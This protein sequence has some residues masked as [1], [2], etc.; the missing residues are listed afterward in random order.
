MIVITKTDHIL[1]GSFPVAVATD[2]DTAE[3]EMDRLF[4][5]I[6]AGFAQRQSVDVS[7]LSASTLERLEE[8]NTFTAS[9][10]LPLVS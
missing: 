3:R 9:F 1:G 8:A 10:A 4:A 2:T 6:V 5:E 7:Q